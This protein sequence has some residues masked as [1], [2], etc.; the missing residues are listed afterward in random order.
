MRR[1]VGSCRPWLIA[2]LVTTRLR[3]MA[4]ATSVTLVPRLT[5]A[6]LARSVKVC[7]RMAGAVFIAA[8]LTDVLCRCKYN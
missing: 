7:C 8:M 6:S 2:W 5:M 3:P 1:R 4:A